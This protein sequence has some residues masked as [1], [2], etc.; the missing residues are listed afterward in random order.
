MI[1]VVCVLLLASAPSSASS[2][3]PVPLR[4][5]DSVPQLDP[6]DV[7]AAQLWAIVEDKHADAITQAR[8]LRL[9]PAVLQ[10]HELPAAS[11]RLAALLAA[12]TTSSA[13]LFD[14]AMA[15]F[16][17][18][19]RSAGASARAVALAAE[20]AQ[21]PAV[22]QAAALMW[23]R[24]GGELGRMAL[25]RCAAHEPLASVRATCIGRLRAPVSTPATGAVSDVLH[26]TSDG[27][28]PTPSGRQLRRS[29]HV[30]Q[31]R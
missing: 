3:V 24:V 19:A 21:A 15:R 20:G 13:L 31:Q 14:V 29:A 2:P 22:R 6:S 28:S 23:W 18:A 9:L 16:E 7:N 26:G 1:A 11:T 25:Q 17:V 4:G 8:A 12:P 10:A 30:P 5:I 27:D